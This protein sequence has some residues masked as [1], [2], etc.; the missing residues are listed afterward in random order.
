MKLYASELPADRTDV[1]RSK[2]AYGTWFGLVVGLT[3]SIFA[4]GFDALQLQQA[5]GFYPWLKFLAGVLPC[6]MV[7]G[8]AGW[9]SARAGKPGWAILLWI[10]AAAIFAWLAVNLPLRITPRILNLIN[11]RVNDFLHY[12]HFEAFNLKFGV[13]YFWLAILT[14]LTGLLQL[15]LTDSAIF[16]TFTFGK[17]SPMLVAIIL[18]AISG[19]TMDDLNNKLLRSP[20][21]AINSTTQYF[22]DHQGEKIEPA[23]TR[24]MH[25][26]S[27]RTVQEVVTPE[28]RY[29]IS[30]YS[31]D[32]GDVQ[33]LTRFQNAWVEC[34]VFY[35]QPLSCQQMGDLP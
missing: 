2:Y 9:F 22:L 4:W 3:Y 13:A 15:P 12:T 25:L 5:N 33:V 19:N 20:I 21:E 30:G 8:L 27:L 31:E 23:Q 26:A 11:P 24:R 35:D 34:E 16:S 7:G 14:A 6:M 29:I 28:R 17:I 18:M 10:I 32:F 1:L